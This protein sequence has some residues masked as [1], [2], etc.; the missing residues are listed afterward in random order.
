MILSTL[1]L[2]E[3]QTPFLVVSETLLLP[4]Y[5]TQKIIAADA[6]AS[7]YIEFTASAG[8]NGMG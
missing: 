5:E 3:I 7:L 4:S 6:C 2:R 1:S 8:G